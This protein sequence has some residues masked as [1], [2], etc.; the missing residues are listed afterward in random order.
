MRSK[1][2]A[3]VGSFPFQVAMFALAILSIWPGIRLL[4]WW[5]CLWFSA[6][7]VCQ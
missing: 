6:A 4:Y 5:H 2:K 7:P 1:L 3:V